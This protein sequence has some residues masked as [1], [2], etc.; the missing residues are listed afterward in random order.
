MAIINGKLGGT[1]PSDGDILT[2]ANFTDTNNAMIEKANYRPSYP[3]IFRVGLKTE[4]MIGH[5]STHMSVIADSGSIYSTADSGV[6]WVVKNTDL[7]SGDYI[8]INC[9]ANRA[10]GV[11]IEGATT[12]SEVILTT[13]SGVTWTTVTS[14]A[15]TTGGAYCV[16]YPTTSLI[17]LGG[18][19]GVSGKHI[20][21][22]TDGGSNWTDATTQPGA[23]IWAVS[24]Y[25][26]TT[27]YAVDSA[28]NIW[29]TADGAVTWTNTGDD[30]SDTGDS[31]NNLV[32]ISDDVC[33]FIGA[34]GVLNHYD[35][36][37]GTIIEK[38][39]LPLDNTTYSLIQTTDG[40]IYC[41]SVN[42]IATGF[43]GQILLISHDSGVTWQ[44]GNI[45]NIV[46]T[47]AWNS[48]YKYM[49]SEA[50]DNQV[51]VGQGN[52]N[53]LRFSLY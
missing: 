16:S 9:K 39:N 45:S 14:A 52:F 31:G 4:V 48:Y 20:V 3:D 41:M 46:T 2:A 18:N 12:T 21:F 47:S 1:D 44:V 53:I 13:N 30:V 43:P 51:M 15:F 35:N 34:E 17:V 50:D 25:D 27:G 42:D 29:K 19:D 7:D 36:S 37:T 11:A 24:M 10:Y 49:L 8:G 40:T 26:G 6:T 38:L 23:A 28:K 33:I 22:S 32:A 5:S